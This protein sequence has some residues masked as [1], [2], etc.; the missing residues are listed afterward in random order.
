MRSVDSLLL[1]AICAYWRRWP[2]PLYWLSTAGIQ[3]AEGDAD[4][5]SGPF[6]VRHGPKVGDGI[7]RFMTAVP[8]RQ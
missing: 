5:A 2:N 6:S 1:K 7:A 8:H 3:P 4:K